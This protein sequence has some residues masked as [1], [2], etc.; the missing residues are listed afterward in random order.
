MYLGTTDSDL[1]VIILKQQGFRG[2]SYCIFDSTKVLNCRRKIS[3]NY[4]AFTSRRLYQRKIL[5][6]WFSKTT[7]L[8]AQKNATLR[9]CQLTLPKFLRRET[10]QRIKIIW[11]G[12]VHHF[13]VKIWLL[14]IYKRAS[15]N[16]FSV[17]KTTVF[18]WQ[19]SIDLFRVCIT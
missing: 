3:K 14:F 11:F 6:G 17:W 7:V 15:Q 4:R 16:W 13:Y 10:L 2:K 8:L 1:K 12:L 5:V 18:K 19:I 9:G